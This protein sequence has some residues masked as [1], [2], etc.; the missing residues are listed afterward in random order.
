MMVMVVVMGW[1]SCHWFGPPPEHGGWVVHVH[2]LV[3]TPRCCRHGTEPSS[4]GGEYRGCGRQTCRQFSRLGEVCHV[5]VHVD[6]GLVEAGDGGAV[7]VHLRGVVQ[8]RSQARH[9]Q[10]RPVS[11]VT[12]SHHRQ[13]LFQHRDGNHS[14]APV[15]H[16]HGDWCD[17]ARGRSSSEA[18]RRGRSPHTLRS[19]CPT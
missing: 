16:N 6:V 4:C 18:S 14:P 3:A 11:N 8:H 5:H 9:L 2:V 12:I 13:Q 10:R 7:A 19:S 1:G 15:H 17:G